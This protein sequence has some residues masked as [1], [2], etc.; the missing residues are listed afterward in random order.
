M[1]IMVLSVFLS[2]IT[3]YY[4]NDIKWKRYM[5]LSSIVILINS[6]PGLVKLVLKFFQC[7]SPINNSTYLLADVDIKC[8]SS[9]HVGI[10]LGLGLPALFLYIIGI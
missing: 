1:P 7:T 2:L 5:I 4:K 8:G 6:H 9:D 10:L 3:Y